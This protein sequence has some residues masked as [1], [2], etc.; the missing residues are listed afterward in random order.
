MKHLITTILILMGLSAD[1]GSAESPIV[2]PP[3][4]TRYAPS[5]PSPTNLS[6]AG[7]VEVYGNFETA[8][9]VV[10]PPQDFPVEDVAAARCELNVAGKWI[11]MHDLVRI[12]SSRRFATSLFWLQPETTYHVRVSLFDSRKQVLATWEGAGKTRAEPLIDSGNREL[13]VSP[14]GDDAQTGTAAKPLRTV[15]KACEIVRAG[16]SIVVHG[17]TYYEG[18]LE[19]SRN[20]SRQVPIIVRSQPGERVILDGSD[21]N[22]ISSKNWKRVG[23]NLYSHDY[24][25][26]TANACAIERESGKI[27]RLFPVPTLKE[28]KERRL[29]PLVGCQIGG[30]FSAMGIEG[31]IF[32]DGSTA[33]LALPKSIENYDLRLPLR[34]RGI[35]LNKKQEIQIAGLE[36][37]H[38]G[39]G[40]FN[41]A[42]FLG[43]SSDIL[44]QNCL[45]ESDNSHVYVKGNSDRV[46]IQDCTFRDAILEW[47]F[48][49][50]KCGE[51]VS[52][53]FEGGAVNVDAAFSGRGL[54][55]R[56]NRIEGLFDGAHLTPWRED[57]APTN[58]IDFYEN[59]IDGCIDDFL[60][61]DGFARNVRIFDNI[62]NR[63]LS[64]ISLAQAL[65]GP[66]FVLY[67]TLANCG[68]VPAAQREENYG[69][70]F[71]TN[72]GAQADVGSGPMFFYHNTAHTTDPQSRALLVKQARWKQL[73]LRNNIWCGEAAGFEL[74]PKDPSPIDWDFD[75]LFVSNLKAPL[76]IQAYR[77][78]YQSL[79]DV[80]RH[81][82][83]LQRGLNVPP[84]FRRQ[85]QG[86]Y[87]LEQT[88]PC[89][90]AGTLIP[91][92]NPLRM[93]GSR[94]DLGAWESE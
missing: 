8:G 57:N 77:T 52:G 38:Y 83:W 5:R 46:T 40:D 18:E 65:D 44:I 76:V 92:I 36:F 72:G 62:M 50:M 11:P 81:F 23:D 47:P 30:E 66:T 15:A 27:I 63:S 59:V 79:E 24:D 82:G 3:S 43:N 48:G 19:F 26:F 75:N 10:S 45:F 80:R 53:Q 16:E 34:N 42:I 14:T 74:W 33:T 39:H 12:G 51:G 4:K 86:D 21:P 32:T 78:N 58:E 88:S 67:N 2:T 7:E 60:E 84:E 1:G 85:A 25:K 22:L 37:R 61:A 35:L 71:K 90:D 20:G 17:G 93:K 41:T 94:P 73:R 28:L 91:G 6:T 70:P 9:V 64:G 54:V 87:R 56:R 69:Y 55:F 31:A 29:V 68:V 89:R 49:Y 13:H